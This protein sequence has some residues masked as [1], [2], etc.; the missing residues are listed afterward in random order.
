M[1][2][3]LDGS[4]RPP[5]PDVGRWLTSGPGLRL[6]A[7]F[8][9][10]A[11]GLAGLTLYEYVAFGWPIGREEAPSFDAYHLVR[12]V[13][14]ATAAA[15]VVIAVMAARAGGCD[16]DRRPLGVAPALAAGLVMAA[17]LAAAGLLVASPQAFHAFA[18]EDS[19]LEWASALLLLGASALFAV[20]AARGLLARGSAIALPA[21][22]AAI[23]FFVLGMEEISWMQRLIGFGTP[24]Q[25]AELN[26]QAEFNLHNIQTDLSELIYYTGAGLFLSVLP[27]LR[28]AA[29]PGLSR[30]PLAAF[31]PGRGIAALAAPAATLTYG[32]WNLLPVQLSFWL[33]IAVLLAFAW[34]AGRQGRRAEGGLFLALALAVAGGQA[35]V[36]ANGA[37]MADLPDASE[38]KELF[39]AFG[40]ACYAAAATRAAAR[41]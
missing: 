31:V 22:L 5:W 39:I 9:L 20:G 12:T 26:W 34:A 13:L 35:M 7:V 33:A 23:A 32:Q 38:Y 16:L 8:L 1:S 15:A 30:H 2:R 40:L 19:P 41:G 36:L 14:A 6:A 10:A 3:P 37:A 4:A 17:G 27:L 28:E 29:S 25:I 11:A 24:D 18:R 21:G